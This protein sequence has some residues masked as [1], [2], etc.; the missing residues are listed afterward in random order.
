MET[1]AHF[2][3]EIEESDVSSKELSSYD[4]LVESAKNHDADYLYVFDGGDWSY[5][6]PNE[7]KK[8]HPLTEDD[9]KLD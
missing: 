9:I 4:E 8:L 3:V 5:C 6:K 1:F 2:M 7:H